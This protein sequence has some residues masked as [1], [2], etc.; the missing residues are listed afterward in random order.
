MGQRLGTPIS[1]NL[2]NCTGYPVS[3]F[4]ATQADQETGTSTAVAVT[5]GVQKYHPA[6]PKAWAYITQSA[7]VYTLAASFGVS[8]INKAAVGR[9]DIT[10]STAFSSTSFA[11]VGSSNEGGFFYSEVLGSRTATNIRALLRTPASVDS[12]VGFS[13]VFYGD[14]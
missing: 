3:Q 11:A 4:A 5:P 7:G 1:G 8:A 14:Q 10:L 9:V 13:V 12:D 2:I 6:H